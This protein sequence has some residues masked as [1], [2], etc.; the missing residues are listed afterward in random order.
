MAIRCPSGG[1][2][3]SASPLAGSRHGRARSSSSGSSPS[4]WMCSIAARSLLVV[5]A[6][7]GER[8]PE[9]APQRCLRAGVHARQQRHGRPQVVFGRGDL[10]AAMPA[11][12]LVEQVVGGVGDQGRRHRAAGRPIRPGHS[13]GGDRL[14]EPLVVPRYTGQVVAVDHGHRAQCGHP[15][16]RLVV[17]IRQL[18]IGGRRDQVERLA[19]RGPVEQF[20]D[21]R[22]DLGQVACVQARVRPLERPVGD[23]DLENLVAPAEIGVRAA[24]GTVPRPLHAP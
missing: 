4:P 14:V 12:R 24:I 6:A 18:V 3:G 21:D 7:G 16:G 22:R 15:G 11:Q 2:W 17:E 9:Q 19:R 20:D 1:R 10:S 23:P 8:R 13:R 5:Q